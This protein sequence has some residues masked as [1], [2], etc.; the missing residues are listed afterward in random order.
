MW[1]KHAS[2]K[3]HVC[4]WFFHKNTKASFANI[5]MME[6]KGSIVSSHKTAIK[7]YKPSPTNLSSTVML[8]WTIYVLMNWSVDEVLL[9]RMAMLMF[10]VLFL[11]G[12]MFLRFS[13]FLYIKQGIHVSVFLS[14][15]YFDLPNPN[16]SANQIALSP[17][18]YLKGPFFWH[19][20]STL[21]V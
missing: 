20:C 15:A 14:R 21:E 16:F 3:T 8:N 5:L 10:G 12:T 1:K 19:H 7:A 17:Q 13:R 9:F 2:T 6:L 18:N 11:W 4:N